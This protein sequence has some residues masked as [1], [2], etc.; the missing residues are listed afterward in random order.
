MTLNIAKYCRCELPFPA[1][2]PA[3]ND[4]AA[5]QPSQRNCCPLASLV[6]VVEESDPVAA[7]ATELWA[8]EDSLE[9]GGVLA[10]VVDETTSSRLPQE[11]KKQAKK[12]K[13]ESV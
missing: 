6:F 3:P 9:P 4:T 8:V 1:T 10:G 13:R 12:K 2:V 5:P 7:Q 11:M